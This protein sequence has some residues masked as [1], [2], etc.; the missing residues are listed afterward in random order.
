MTMK[1]E[2]LKLIM[3]NKIKLVYEVEEYQ[4]YVLSK[5][6]KNGKNDASIT[7]TKIILTQKTRHINH[8]QPQKQ[9]LPP[10]IIK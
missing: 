6:Q 7:S 1:W 10:I 9:F 5:K 2:K 8:K 3:L 4:D